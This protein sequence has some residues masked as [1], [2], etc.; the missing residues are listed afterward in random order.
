[1]VFELTDKIEGSEQRVGGFTL[2]EQRFQDAWFAGQVLLI[3]IAGC[4]LSVAGVRKA[5]S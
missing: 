5:E 4:R 1:M 3:D 2:P